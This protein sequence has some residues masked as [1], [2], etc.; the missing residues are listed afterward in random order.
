[1]SAANFFSHPSFPSS[2][3]D[4]IDTLEFLNASRGLVWLIGEFALHF[5]DPAPHINRNLLFTLYV[6]LLQLLM[7]EQ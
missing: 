2:I 4:R 6:I 5:K 3:Q 7:V 1:M